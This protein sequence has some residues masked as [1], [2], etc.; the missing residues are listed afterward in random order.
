MIIVLYTCYTIYIVYGNNT[1]VFCGL[2]DAKIIQLI[3]KYEQSQPQGSFSLPEE[4]VRP[5]LLSFERVHAMFYRAVQ[6]IGKS[7]LLSSRQSHFSFIPSSLFCSSSLF[8]LV[9][10][11]LFHS[12]YILPITVSTSAPHFSLSYPHLY[13]Q[14]ALNPF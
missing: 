6:N 2:R 1:N 10:A 3:A 14:I 13:Y 5:Y 12:L 11:F 7:R 8:S 9:H 4:I